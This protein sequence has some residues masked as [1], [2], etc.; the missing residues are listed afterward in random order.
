MFVDTQIISYAKAG[1]IRLPIHGA[2]ISSVAASELLLVYGERRTA[3]NYYVPLAFTR[4]TEA[5]FTPLK[6]DHPPSKRSTDRIVF[7]FGSD[8]E[9]LV[10][11]GSLAIARMV[12]D[13]N[14]DLLGL[15]ISFRDKQMQRIVRDNYRFLVERE[16]RCVPLG[17][18]TVEIAY[19]LLD[20]FRPSG[21]RF[22]TTFV[23]R[24][25]TF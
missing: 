15:S 21:E 1:L 23:T 8:Y 19:R 18:G 16:I 5:S 4:R 17:P 14:S 9:P 3:A 12:N 2:S 7:S 10:E 22:R 24:G 13:R 20:K 6:I 25:T 11:F